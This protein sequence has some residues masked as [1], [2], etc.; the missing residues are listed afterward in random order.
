MQ[1]LHLLFFPICMLRM[2]KGA[3]NKDKTEEHQQVSFLHVLYGC[4]LFFGL[5][6]VLSIYR[7]TQ[8]SQGMENEFSVLAREKFLSFLIWQNV[9]LLWVY[10]CL[11]LIF[12]LGVWPFVSGLCRKLNTKRVIERVLCA[13]GAAFLLHVFFVL[14][15]VDTKPYFLVDAKFGY[16]YYEI[17]N[18]IPKLVKPGVFFVLFKIIPAL[19]LLYVV[20]WYLRK[21][22][23]KLRI[24]VGFVFS[25]GFA[26]LLGYLGIEH[27]RKSQNHSKL[28]SDLPMNVLVI[29]SD[30]LRGDRLGYAGYR[31]KRK[32]GLAAEGVSP[33]IDALAKESLNFTRCYTPIAYTLESG[34]S[35]MA[36]QYP[37][38]H[39]L[40]HMYPNEKLVENAKSKTVPLAEILGKKGYDTAAFGDWCAGFYELM[41]L[42]FD[43]ISVSSFDNFKIYMSQAVVMAHFVIPLYMD[44]SLG[45]SVFP[46]L[47]SFAQFVTP[48]LVTDRVTRR[49]SEVA[50]KKQPFFWHVFYS[51]NHLPFRSHEPFNTMFSDPNYIGK[52]R[53]GVDFDI[54]A[55]IGE[56]NLED[57][58]K[59]LP[60]EEIQQIR[61]LYDGCTRHFDHHVGL[62]LDALKKNGLMENTIVVLTSDHGDNLY[63]EGVTLG[64]GLTF[65]GGAKS[66]HIPLLF[67]VPKIPAETFSKQVRS[68]DVVP[69][70]ADILGLEIPESWEGQS[71]M[72]W[73]DGREKPFSRPFYGETGF[74]FIQLQVAGVERPN[75]APMDEMTGI[76]DTFQYQFVLKDE[77][78]I[79]LSAAKQRCLIT[80]RWK[81]VLTPTRDG[82]RHFALYSTHPDPFSEKDVSQ[83]HPEIL[84]PMKRA[85]E[86][87]VD[88]KIETDISEIFPSGE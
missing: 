42:G 60:A 59:A 18:H 68:I 63:E 45:Y 79:P 87:W 32:D 29:G 17:L 33:N 52:N 41:P 40:R 55:F 88:Q 21:L 77:Y 72:G 50:V 47:L 75:L 64:H 86:M 46:Q 28:A 12:S 34:V 48:D 81:L 37:H 62:I 53:T 67:Y 65:Q 26:A 10:V 5:Q 83:A 49:L 27:L 23:W 14:R 36:S 25:L 11:A 15:L 73:I 80:D 13:F 70:L 4:G 19:G 51:C 66:N 56:T 20:W 24:V 76:D 54:D 8:S 44:H 69:T 1:E 71:L 7:L 6:F 74:P 38:T 39:G 78:E 43:H 31:P 22:S 61:D 30:S 16:W 3:S 85:L 2:R 35:F 84:A 58:W 82:H 9:Q 57:K